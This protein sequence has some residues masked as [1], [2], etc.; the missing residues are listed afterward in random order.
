MGLDV[1]PDLSALACYL[2]VLAAGALASLFQLYDKLGTFRGAWVMAETWALYA[3]YTLFPVALFWLL[4]RT[5]AIHDTS[6]FAALIIGVGYQQILSGQLSSIKA[7]SEAA[8]FWQFFS[9]WADRMS[10]RIR[11]RIQSADRWFKEAT[12]NSVLGS[13]QRFD[14]L[15]QLAMVVPADPAQLTATLAS[16]QALQGQ[17][18]DRGVLERQTRVLCDTVWDV[19]AYARR[20]KD[21][22]IISR[23]TYYWYAQE[24]RSKTAAI[25]IAAA[26]AGAALVAVHNLY[27]P[28]N[29]LRYYLWR[30]AKPNATRADRLRTRK[31]LLAL[32][33]QCPNGGFDGIAEVLTNDAL[34]LDVITQTTDL[35]IESHGVGAP[36]A[37]QLPLAIVP[38]LWNINP[39]ARRRIQDALVYMAKSDQN[40]ARS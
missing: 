1:S 20:L 18:G 12:V 24:W 3:V 38:S 25:A 28:G 39:D 7:P 26:L 21:R 40:H 33:A 35:I 36:C 10:A 29:E 17:I 4:D 2:V 34:P 31:A 11:T 23:F 9:T 13:Q 5:N 30:L 8:G 6:L 32:F 15:R 27:S 37:A 22:G 19:D 16:I 14:A